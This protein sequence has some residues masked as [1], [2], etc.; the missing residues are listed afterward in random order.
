MASKQTMVEPLK[1]DGG[2]GDVAGY[3]TANSKLLSKAFPQSPII[4]R[5][6]MTDESVT[7]EYED[8]LMKP[9]NDGGYYFG[10]YNPTYP[11]APNLED[12]E[13]G[14][15]GLPATPFVPNVASPGVGSTNPTDLPEPPNAD[16][17]PTNQTYGSGEGRI[18]PSKTAKEIAKTKLGDYVMSTN[19]GRSQ[20]TGD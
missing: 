19:P 8:V 5:Q 2:L 1:T 7:A 17:V 20:Y 4:G 12:V 10:E 11:D 14:A 13:T 15:A 9:I 16:Q 3:S 6:T 18:S